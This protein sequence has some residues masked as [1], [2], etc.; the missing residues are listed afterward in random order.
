M[1]DNRFA[2]IFNI[3]QGPQHDEQMFQLLILMTVDD[4]QDPCLKCVTSIDGLE[5]A[6]SISFPDSEDGESLQKS[7]DNQTLDSAKEI[8]NNLL[9]HLRELQNTKG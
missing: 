2:K 5:V 1:T 9:A 6:L 7:F 8:F 4:D 3:K